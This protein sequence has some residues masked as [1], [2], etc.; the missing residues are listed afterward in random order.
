[1]RLKSLIGLI[2]ILVALVITA[3]ASRKRFVNDTYM[4]CLGLVGD[5]PI[6]TREEQTLCACM[7]EQAVTAVPWKSRLPRSLITLNEDD[8]ARIVAAQK[9]CRPTSES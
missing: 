4:L 8:N 1:M 5:G 7:A 3:D 2:A 6:V 9:S